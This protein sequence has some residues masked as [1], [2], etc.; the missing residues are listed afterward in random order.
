MLEGEEG[1]DRRKREKCYGY[2]VNIWHGNFVLV[3][4]CP[5]CNHDRRS[6]HGA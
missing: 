6:R 5:E 3:I 4:S 1:R 2:E